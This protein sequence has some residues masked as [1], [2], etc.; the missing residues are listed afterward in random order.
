MANVPSFEKKRLTNKRNILN[1]SKNAK[2]KKGDP[3]I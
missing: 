2:I 1:Y 3:S